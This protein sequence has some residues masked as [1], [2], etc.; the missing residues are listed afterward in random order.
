MSGSTTV[1]MYAVVINASASADH[2]PAPENSVTTVEY[3][4]HVKIEKGRRVRIRVHLSIVGG[5]TIEKCVVEYVHGGGTMLP[6]LEALMIG[7]EQGAKLDGVLAAKDAFG[8]PSMHPVKKM[9]RAEFPKEA[10]LVKGEK[11]AAKG[12]N[13]QDVVLAVESVGDDEIDIRLVHPLAES[14]IKY[15]VEVL[16]VREPVRPPPIPA[17]ALKLEEG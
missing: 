3:R 7:K 13:G 17:A 1:S 11:F 9:K 14:D 16:E 6:G 15:D 2:S 4:R 10:K 8:N 12:V 5:D